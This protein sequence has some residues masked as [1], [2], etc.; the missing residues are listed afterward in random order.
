MK[1][2]V[3]SNIKIKTLSELSD[4]KG[5]IF[6]TEVTYTETQ[7]EN[8]RREYKAQLKVLQDRINELE[9]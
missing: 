3:A 4:T 6:E 7:V 1:R 8:I 2:S 9:A 5:E